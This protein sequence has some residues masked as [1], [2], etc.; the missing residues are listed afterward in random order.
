MIN[1]VF[2]SKKWVK[3]EYKQ[4]SANYLV[5]FN[6]LAFE[7]LLREI[8]FEKQL[9]IPSKSRKRDISNY[10][11]LFSKYLV[12]PL[13]VNFHSYTASTNIGSNCY[14][15]ALILVYF[16]IFQDRFTIGGS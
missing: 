14:L 4:I 11:Y 16:R 3:I 8:V 13:N 15:K 9:D 6:S 1:N 12:S 5:F 2:K 7:N 10:C